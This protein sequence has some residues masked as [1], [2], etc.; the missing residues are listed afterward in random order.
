MS[1]PAYRDWL[2]TWEVSGSRRREGGTV[3]P[4]TE[5]VE[6]SSAKLAV[7]LARLRL[8]ARGFGQ[9]IVTSTR[10]KESNR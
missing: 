4:F 9:I 7:E 10:R 5:V 1:R 8:Y 2:P 3:E 6:S